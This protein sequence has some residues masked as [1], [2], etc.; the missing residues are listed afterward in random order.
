MGNGGWGCLRTYRG[1]GDGVYEGAYGRAGGAWDLG[2]QKGMR[3]SGLYERRPATSHLPHW[4]SL[5]LPGPP[6]RAALRLAQPPA[7]CGALS[8]P[9]TPVSSPPGQ[10]LCLRLH[11]P[12]NST[13]EQVSHACA[14]QMGKGEGWELGGALGG[15]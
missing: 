14:M 7:P 5:E 3:G 12:P 2:G 10:S 15:S 6:A 9:L 1:V 8:W 13:Q 4:D 11:L